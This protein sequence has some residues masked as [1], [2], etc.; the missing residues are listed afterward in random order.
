V[1]G[2]ASALNGLGDIAASQGDFESAR[3]FHH[4]SLARYRE[5]D[6]RWGIAGVLADLAQVDVQ[7][8][9]DA[10]ATGTL[11]EALR[12]FRELGHQRGVA[13]QLESLAWCAGRQ[14]RDE[15]AVALASAAATMRR[16]IG[17]PPKPGERD[18][19]DATLA[20]ARSRMS[21]EAYANAWREGARH[22]S[23]RRLE[24]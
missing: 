15:E 22:P 1:R 3:R 11:I 12:A 9:D 4:D 6:D 17:T 18:R 5:I 20:Q 24:I 7:A 23:V 13:R 8:S 14:S 19:L 2:V 16:K 21:A 10:A